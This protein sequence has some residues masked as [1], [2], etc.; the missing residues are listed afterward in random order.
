MA[1]LISDEEEF[2]IKYQKSVSD[3]LLLKLTLSQGEAKRWRENGNF[4]HIR[5]EL[6]QIEGIEIA[7]QTYTVPVPTGKHMCHYYFISPTREMMGRVYNMIVQVL[8]HGKHIKLVDAEPIPPEP[9]NDILYST[10]KQA[11]MNPSCALV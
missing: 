8:D 5:K 10:Y 7:C 3:D 1:R 4:K 2:I 6:R 9:D 11:S